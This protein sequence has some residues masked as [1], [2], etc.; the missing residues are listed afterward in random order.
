SDTKLI[1]GREKE[2][3]TSERNENTRKL[4]WSVVRIARYRA[5]HVPVNHR[6]GTYHPYRT[7]QGGTENLDQENL[8][9][10]PF[11]DPNPA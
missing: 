7:V 6:T 10:K 11:L 8:N 4:S 1:P 2:E 3:W 9:A 5:I